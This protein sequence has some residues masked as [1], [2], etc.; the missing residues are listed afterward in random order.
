MKK[1]SVLIVDDNDTD[2]YLLKRD[3]L[4]AGIETSVVFEK[5]DG[6]EA[7]AFFADYEKNR[8]LYPNDFPPIIVFLDINMPKMNGFSFLDAFKNIR[9]ETDLSS[10]IF[11]MFSS[12]DRETD[13]KRAKSFGFVKDYLVKGHYDVASLK[14]KIQDLI[15][16][17]PSKV[18]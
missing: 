2:R 3:L 6:E 1:V 16:Q 4:E 9:E 12:S 5:K 17:A 7:L 11:M 8:A 10:S 18:T 14:D 13:K 15:D